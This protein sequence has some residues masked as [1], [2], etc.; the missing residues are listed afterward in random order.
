VPDLDAAIRSRLD[1]QEAIIKG[2]DNGILRVLGEADQ[3]KAA[4]IA[5]LERH[6]PGYPDGPEHE[7]IDV[8]VFDADGTPMGH[9]RKEGDL[10]PGYYCEMCSEFSPCPTMRDIAKEL[11]VEPDRG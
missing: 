1:S 3:W 10:I 9:V 7:E 4:L 6:K 5:A 8:P 11:G 2:A